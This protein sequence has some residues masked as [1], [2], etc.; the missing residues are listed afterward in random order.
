MSMQRIAA[1]VYALALFAGAVLCALRA[2]AHAHLKTH[3]IF[4]C[5]YHHDG[6]AAGAYPD[7]YRSD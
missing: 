1:P 3:A 4:R 2:E 5:Q 6:C 7:L